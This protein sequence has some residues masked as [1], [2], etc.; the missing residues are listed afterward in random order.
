MSKQVCPFCGSDQITRATDIRTSCYEWYCYNCHEFF[1][2]PNTLVSAVNIE[3]VVLPKIE[4]LS[5]VT[6]DEA[7]HSPN[8]FE[9]MDKINEI[10]D[11]I[12]KGWA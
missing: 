2:A 7:I 9:L 5:T 10:I 6:G 4:K 11:Y 3:D 1:G 12:N 8:N